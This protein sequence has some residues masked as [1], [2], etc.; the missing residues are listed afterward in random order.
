MDTI[1]ENDLK[2]NQK[3][4][5]IENTADKNQISESDSIDKKTKKTKRQTKKQKENEEKENFNEEKK[6]EVISEESNQNNIEENKEVAD[7][8]LTNHSH[9]EK[10]SKNK[11]IA[12]SVIASILVVFALIFSTIF[13]LANSSSKKI[14]KGV[15]VKGVNVSGLT[16]E[17]AKK[18]LDS[19][20]NHK[21]TDSFDLI[22]NDTIYAITP[23]KLETVYDI[24]K[25]IDTAFEVGR[26]NNIFLNNYEILSAMLFKKIIVPSVSYN[27]EVLDKIIEEIQDSFPDKLVQPSYY[28][29][30]DKL[31]ITK[32]SNGLGIDTNS[33][34]L[35][36][37]TNLSS[38]NEDNLDI[39]LPVKD[40]TADEIDID[41]IHD[42]IYK[43][44]KDAY[45]E[46][47]PFTIYPHEIGVDFDISIDE[48][49]AL[50]KEDK[51]T[52]EIPLK[53]TNPKVMTNEI[54]SES[55]PNLLASYSTTYSTKNV[56][57]STNISLASNKV[58]G[59]VVMPGEVF[60][61]NKTVGERT[62][63]AG[64][65][66]AAVY[67]GGEVTTGIGGGI[68]QVSSTIYNS[69]LLSNLEIVE[70]HNHGFNPGYVPAGRDATVSW[71]G[72]D[73]KFKNTRNFPIRI[74]CSGTGGKILVEIYGIKEDNE[75][76]VSIESYITSYIKYQTI[77]KHDPSLAAG[78]TK[79]IESGSNGCRSVCYRIL[80][81]NGAII[82]K[83]L[84]S[85]D[86]YAPHN[87]IVSV[88]SGQSQAPSATVT[89]VPASS[90]TP[91]PKPTT[92]P[93]PTPTPKPTVTPTLTP[94]AGSQN[95]STNVTP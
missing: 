95:S 64:F 51:E 55:F 71:G 19:I 12:V 89:D 37:I 80:K 85:S 44:P 93:T 7:S 29:E 90:P 31:I 59:T 78:Q 20:I 23:E 26:K 40:M 36:I 62:S 73:F 5:E 27:E 49:K 92:A 38:I 87:R 47:E 43:E 16:K 48:A 50:L 81:Q 24:D 58:N 53:L 56:N 18:K 6:E 34:K 63:K 54:G 15:S 8:L 4:E 2:E 1:T 65:K 70:R 32:G 45:F 41:K 79:V 61:Y 57:R 10:S 68:C 75:P 33:L 39:T 11:I 3:I 14:V 86:T 22:Y 67:L 72:P 30:D 94:T 46:K 82:S 9:S 74:I 60:S 21:L 76:E 17:E 52:Y 35:K 25:S 66:E 13:A 42:E 91:T 88:G 28:I 84:L 77:E 83:T 69:A